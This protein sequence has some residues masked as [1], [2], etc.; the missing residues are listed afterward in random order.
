MTTTDCAIGFRTVNIIKRLGLAEANEE[1]G[2]ESFVSNIYNKCKYYGLMPDKLVIL[3][4]QI[5]D[6]L[7]YATFTNSKLCR[8][9]IKR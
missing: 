1:K 9:K 6:L 3:A 4:M 7:E 5:L 8:R 2:L